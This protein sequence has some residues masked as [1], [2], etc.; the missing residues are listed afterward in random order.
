MD[1]RTHDFQPATALSRQ[2]DAQ[3]KQRLWIALAVLLVAVLA[4]VWL[5]PQPIP[6]ETARV[7]RG[8]LQVSVDE[9]GRVR[10]HDT[11]RVAA[12][13]AGQLMRIALREGDPVR[14]GEVVATLEPL[15]LDARQRQEAQARLD[16]AQARAREAGLQARSASADLALAQSERQRIERLVRDNFVSHQAQDKTI[17]VE[18]VAR[19]ALEAARFR[20]RAAQADVAVAQAALIGVFAP[21]GQRQLPLAAPVDGNVLTVHERS[22]GT[23]AAGAPLITIGDP[24]RYE[25]VVDVLSSDAVKVRPGNLMLLED[26]GGSRSLRARVRL[27]EPVAFTKIS[28]LG[29]EEQRVNIVADP[30]DG[31]GR[32]G[33]GYRVQARIVIWSED[34]VVKAPGSSLFRAG[35]DWHVFVVDGGRLHERR[36]EIGQRNQDEV[37]L[38]SGVQLGAVLVRYVG[39]QLRD[40]AR[41]VI[42]R[43]NRSELK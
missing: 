3:R 6:V 4:W 16:A 39:N 38:V 26:W 20:E 40:G 12:P 19:A 10:A 5:A 9:E 11:Y 24:A 2:R 32:L 31:L 37:Q 14:M 25:I 33:D 42:P 27:V 28:A 41:V 21:P 7:V 18:K 15:P 23:V 29:V 1:T 34:N 43:P 8:P 30:V 36:V 17:T 35:D 22:A 13:V